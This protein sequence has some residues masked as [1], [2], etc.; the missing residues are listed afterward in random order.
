MRETVSPAAKKYYNE[1]L[2]HYIRQGDRPGEAAEKA[3]MDL[4]EWSKPLDIPGLD[5]TEGLYEL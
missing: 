4:L 5:D 1:R 2:M 3:D